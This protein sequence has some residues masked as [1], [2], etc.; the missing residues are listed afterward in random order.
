MDWGLP[1]P[2]TPASDSGGYSTSGNSLPPFSAVAGEMNGSGSRHRSGTPGIH[3]TGL[4]LAPLN[5][6][7]PG[8]STMLQHRP[9]L[10]PPMVPPTPLTNLA[11]NG[12]ISR[13]FAA[14][15]SV[16]HNGPIGHNGPLP[17]LPLSTSPP[18]GVVVVGSSPLVPPRNGVNGR[19]RT[20]PSSYGQWQNGRS[21]VVLDSD[22]ED[23]MAISNQLARQSR[24]SARLAPLSAPL[25]GSLR[26]ESARS[27]LS[28]YV[29][30]LRIAF[31][32][33]VTLGPGRSSDVIDLT[34][35]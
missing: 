22:D 13:R 17:P 19:V 11:Q 9:T 30:S 21:V 27:C 28:G 2:S 34:L 15:S 7:P 4:Q 3:S 8:G 24:P 33:F 16:T 6:Q 10:L 14:G 29:E 5:A 12:E 35:D 31:D 20:S 23:E 1:T 18:N 26:G 32:P 25:M